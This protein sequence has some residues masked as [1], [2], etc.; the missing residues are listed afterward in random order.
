M[1]EDQSV[2]SAEG[3]KKRKYYYMINRQTDIKL[4]DIYRNIYRDRVNLTESEGGDDAVANF[5]PEKF[6][7]LDMK[8]VRAKYRLYKDFPFFGLILM[9]LKTVITTDIPTMAVDDNNNIYINPSF[10]LNDLSFDEM[11]GV[12]AH[13]T[14]HVANLTLF[15]LRGRH[16][17]L[18]NIATDYIMNRDLLAN[19]L[20]LPSL[21]LIPVNSNDKWSI[22]VKLNGKMSTID[23]TDMTAEEL[24]DAIITQAK[25]NAQN[26][27]GGQGGQGAGINIS[28][29]DDLS[30]KQQELDKH[31]KGSE[32][33]PKNIIEDPDGDPSYEPNKGSEGPEHDKQA[34]AAAR[35]AVSD[36]LHQ[37]NSRGLGGSLPRSFN[38]QIYTPKTDYKR[39]LKD[40]VVASSRTEYTWKRPHKRWLSSG[41]YA[42]R[43]KNVIDDINGVIAIDTSGSIVNEILNTFYN[44]LIKLMT[45]FPK[46]RM[47]ILFWHDRVYK[48]VDIKSAQDARNLFTVDIQ[49]G[50]TELSSIKKY[51]DSKGVKQIDALLIFTDGYVES[52]TILPRCKKRPI[53]MINDGGTDKYVKSLG[54]VYNVDIPH[55]T[56]GGV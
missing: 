10:A 15:R 42:P 33:K 6:K 54:T 29:L 13:E 20:K 8:I 28:D 55:S 56:R 39:I 45:T 38:S 35:S 25:Q 50:G 34:E 30:N 21:G 12:L 40:F 52:N 44:E 41:I 36:A 14:F 5:P 53:F 48:D 17:E 24:Y 19:G 32:G 47:R 23:I 43:P 9:R 27:Q 31:I 22:K 11:V 18:W 37:I 3:Y 26:G 49:S 2:F 1:T 16:H 46:A 4:Y 7:E 51:L